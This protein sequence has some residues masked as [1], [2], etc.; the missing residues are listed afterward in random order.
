MHLNTHK[1]FLNP[2]TV[3]FQAGLKS[4][5]VLTDL[6]AGSGFYALAAANTV[7]S[8]GAVHVVDVKDTA[9]EHVSTEARMRG[10]KTVKTY[11][12]NLDNSTLPPRLPQ[13]ESDMVVL[14]NI[15][16]EVNDRKQLLKHAYALL[17]TGGRLVV[18]DWND[19]SGPIGPPA[20]K[21][22]S[23]QDARKQIETSS[24]KYLKN[25]DADEYHFGL[26]FE[27]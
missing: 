2:Q 21:R 18:V 22:I 14:A 9:L 17:K 11:T 12:A 25:L 20:D 26:V 5:Q 24:F 23:E 15:M 27:K 7:G 6:G 3:L 13:G 8:Q 1:K 16:H 10:F 4:G 19:R